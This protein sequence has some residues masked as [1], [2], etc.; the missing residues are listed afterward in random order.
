MVEIAELFRDGGEL[1]RAELFDHIHQRAL[2]GKG[3]RHLHNPA[4]L[5]DGVD[6]GPARGTAVGIASFSLAVGFGT[7]G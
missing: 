1:V 3:I 6:S 7:P 4:E 5:L 2:A